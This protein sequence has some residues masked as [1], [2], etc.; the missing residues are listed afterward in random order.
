MLEFF[1]KLNIAVA[2]VSTLYTLQRVYI[3]NIVYSYWLRL[4]QKILG[5]LQA[6][7]EPI[8]V[9]AD[10]QYDSPGHSA[11]HC[12]YR[13]GIIRY[14][15]FPGSGGYSSSIAIF[16]Q[17]FCIF[18]PFFAFICL[19]FAFILNFSPKFC[20]FS[21]F[22]TEGQRKGI[23]QF[24]WGNGKDPMKINKDI[25]RVVNRIFLPYGIGIVRNR[26]RNLFRLRTRT[27]YW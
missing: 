5:T 22:S 19:I 17:F 20:N 11:E 12:F 24:V 26:S 3:N 16:L 14:I 18:S 13:L 2:C 7:G 25:L 15:D 8:C 21:P 23:Y 10:G 27:R 4:Q 1:A 9:S 6:R